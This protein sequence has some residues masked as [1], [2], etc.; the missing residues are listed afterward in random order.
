MDTLD[1]RFSTGGSSKVG[2]PVAK[3]IAYSDQN[4][5]MDMKNVL[6]SHPT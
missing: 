1:R 4:V 2:L 3:T 5:A 6:R